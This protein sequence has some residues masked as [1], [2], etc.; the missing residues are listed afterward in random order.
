[1]DITKI[2]GIGIIG[3]FL[4]VTVRSYR[5]ELGIGVA[6]AVGI[7]IFMMTVP[8]FAELL[9]GVYALCENSPISTE[10]LKIIIKII[11]IAYITQFSA[12]LAKD[13]GEGAVAKKLEFAGKASVL[14]LMMP[15]VQN[16]LDV[17]IDT[18]MSF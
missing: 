9:S 17:I 13:A 5:P 4:A 16:L 7:A 18:L 14:V 8:I 2:I 10:Y 15:I 12:E 11:G 1:M 6:I 3:I